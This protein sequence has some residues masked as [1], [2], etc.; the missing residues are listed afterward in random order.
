MQ[1]KIA[2]ACAA[3]TLAASGWLAAAPVRGDAQAPPILIESLAG[4]DSFR[5]Y[6]VPCHGATGRGD[7]PVSTAWHTRAADLTTLAQRH[8]GK[9]PRGRVRDVVSGMARPLPAHGTTEMPVWG[10]IFRAF[11]SEPRARQRI[12]SLLSYIESIQVPSTGV[13]DVGSQLFRTHCAICHGPSGRGDGAM[14][15]EMRRTP[16]DLTQYT[17]RN[18]G[19][20]PEALVYRIVEGGEVSSHG[21]REMPVWGDVFKRGASAADVRARIEAI[22]RYLAGIQERGA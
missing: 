7:G 5:A 21:N 6:C 12:E 1:R 16:P 22:V 18:G 2:L 17:R 9:F 20:F 10:P 15:G 11:E 13:H 8:E 4:I 19:V 3:V 14:A